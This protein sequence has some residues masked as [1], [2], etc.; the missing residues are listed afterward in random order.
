MMAETMRGAMGGGGGGGGGD[1]GQAA[2]AAPGRS[3]ADRLRDLAA[4]HKEGVISAE[5][6]QTKRAEL[7]KQL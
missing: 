7:V 4:L 3:V 2:P 6:Y 1:G 5:E